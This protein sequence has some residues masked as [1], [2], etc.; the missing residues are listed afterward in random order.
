MGARHRARADT[1][2]ILK[3]EEIAANKCR[4]PNITQFHN[5]KIRFPLPHRIVK[6]RGLSRFTT[7]KPRTHFY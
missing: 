6:R 2:Q 4:R 1:I 7:V 5:S 3:V